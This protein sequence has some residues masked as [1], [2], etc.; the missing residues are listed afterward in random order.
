MAKSCC[1]TETKPRP[2]FAE[3][4]VLYKPL[5]VFFL[6]SLCLS[7]ALSFA[8]HISF[9]NAFMGFALCFLASLK[10][11]NIK[12]FANSFARYDI[13]A[14]RSSAYSYG[15]PFI[16]LFLS[17]LYFAGYAPVAT[18]SLMFIIM[19]IG[20]IGII[21]VIKSGESMQCAC[22]GTTFNLPVGKVTLFENIVMGSMAL[23]MLAALFMSS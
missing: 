7:A 6:I 12:G 16:E 15:Y 8:G 1:N 13:I 20:S 23:Y 3:K 22:V 11:L 18:N 4:L 14:C 9:M 19:L 5:I 21:K 17:C 10:F 2:A